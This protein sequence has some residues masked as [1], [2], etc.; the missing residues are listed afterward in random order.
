[1]GAICGSSGQFAFRSRS[2]NM[3]FRK[4]KSDQLDLD[5]RWFDWIDRHRNTLRDLGLPPE[6]YLSQ[7]HW[8]DFLENGHLHWHRQDST[9]FNFGDLSRS[10]MRELLAF[11][12]H[13]LEICPVHC[14][15]P[16]YLRV[17]LSNEDV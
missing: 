7:D 11:L 16:G 13:H 12:E 2:S 14:P 10:Q 5:S 1:M 3:A 8:N 15:L 4:N 6:V 17:R 9:A